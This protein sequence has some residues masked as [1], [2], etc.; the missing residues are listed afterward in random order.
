MRVSVAATIVLLFGLSIPA[1]ADDDPKQNPEAALTQREYNRVTAT[2]PSPGHEANPATPP[3]A[4]HALTDPAKAALNTVHAQKII[5][6]KRW[7]RM[8]PEQRD[9]QL[10]GFQENAPKGTTFIL[11]VA[12]G[13][14]YLVPPAD[15]DNTDKD[16]KKAVDDLQGVPPGSGTG[17]IRPWQPW[18]FA[19]LPV[20][21]S[22]V[23]TSGDR[24]GRGDPFAVAIGLK[25]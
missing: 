17:L 5:G 21:V 14:V 12:T 2:A 22:N 16:Y 24:A 9:D 8:S 15:P 23:P 1:G 20:A 25:F 11:E 6:G 3:V 4:V 13:D 7:K 19:S 10:R 18:E